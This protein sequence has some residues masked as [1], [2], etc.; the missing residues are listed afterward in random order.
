M[1]LTGHADLSGAARTINEG[2]AFR[3]LLKP[4]GR[5]DLVA[6][7]CAGVDQHEL[8]TAEREL[9]DRTCA[10]ASVHSPKCCHSHAH[11]R[12]RERREC[13]GSQI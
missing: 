10:V 9:L 4:V 8:V 5:A 11:R 13:V 2:D 3:M 12:S 7:L 6:A 1:M